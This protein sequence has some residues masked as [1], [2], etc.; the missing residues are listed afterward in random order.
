MGKVE[1]GS[2]VPM[3]ELYFF[4]FIS[5]QVNEF[6][7][8]FDTRVTKVSIEHRQALLARDGCLL[9]LATIAPFQLVFINMRCLPVTP[10]VPHLRARLLNEP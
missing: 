9:V 2:K 1:H 6:V 3:V 10:R 8:S 7:T 4:L 5:S